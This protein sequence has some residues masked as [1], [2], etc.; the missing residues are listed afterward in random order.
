MSNKRLDQLL[1]IL[2]QL[3]PDP[4]SELVFKNDF[5]L[6]V[7]VVLS[8]QCTDKKVNEVTP[9]L[10]TKFSDFRSLA[11]AKLSDIE[12]IIRPINYFKTKSKNLI[13]L[14]IQIER[15]FEGKIPLN[16]KDITTLSGVGRKTANVVLGELG[17]DF[18]LPV[19]THVFRVSKRL[20]LS[21]GK[22]PNEVEEDL[23]K[24]FP[25]KDWRSL[26]HW[27][28]FHGRRVCAARSPKCGECAL[29]EICPSAKAFGQTPLKT[30]G[31][32]NRRK[33]SR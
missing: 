31:N 17:V 30:I 8:A 15:D 33:K 20:G 5:Q 11:K 16:F 3:Y 26:H 1:K 2:G 28:I 13:S 27:L 14:G 10:F 29:K 7:S 19:D 12:E 4:K 6:I 18:T 21:K 25:K 9:A 24:Q 23:R 22:N 32:S